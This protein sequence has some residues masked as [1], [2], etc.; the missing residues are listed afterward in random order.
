MR[1]EEHVTDLEHYV[2][3]TQGEHE[4]VEEVEAGRGKLKETVRE[5]DAIY[6]IIS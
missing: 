4:K 1:F 3:S 2:D 6:I 5:N